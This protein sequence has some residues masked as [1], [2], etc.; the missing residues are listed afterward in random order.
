MA[1]GEQLLSS[2]QWVVPLSN[3][4]K[5]DRVAKNLADL[6]ADYEEQYIRQWNDFLADLTVKEPVTIKEA[7]ESYRILSEPEWPYL[8]VLRAVEDHTQWKKDQSALEGDGAQKA[9]EKASKYASSKLKLD[10]K[11]D[12]KQIAGRASRV[13]AVFKKTVEFGVPQG[14]GQGPVTDTALAKYVSRL[15]A[16]RE[17]MA[18]VADA[19]PNADA[20]VLGSRLADASKEAEAMLQ[21]FDDKARTVLQPLLIKPLRIG[22]RAPAPA[23]E[24]A[25]FPI[26]SR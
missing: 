21:P 23:A 17:E 25:R 24:G 2:E 12:V 6:A 4:E 5:G 11:V 26:P 14:A 7:I 18:R 3:E 8:R 19:T 15:G 22:G 9:S 20:R 1:A 16:L 13:P 10:I